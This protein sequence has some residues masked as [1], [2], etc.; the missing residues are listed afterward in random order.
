MKRKILR[1]L[2]IVC[3]LALLTV[4]A[5]VQTEKEGCTGTIFSRILALVKEM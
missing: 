1:S 2:I 3:G 5:S 4:P